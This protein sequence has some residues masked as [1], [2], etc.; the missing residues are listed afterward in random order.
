MENRL[1][2]I[3]EGTEPWKQ[4]CRDTW[5]SYRESYETLNT[6]QQTAHGAGSARQRLF[7]NGIKAVLGKKGPI[8][9]REGATKEDTVFF[10]WP[11]GTAFT[12]LTD[13]AAQ[14]FVASKTQAAPVFGTLDGKPIYKKSG[15]FGTYCVWNSTNVP[16]TPE[17]TPDTIVA[18]LKA[19]SDSVLHTLG[20]FVF[21]SGQYGPFMYKA[22]TTGKARKFVGIPQALD[23]KTLTLEAATRIFQEGL[24]Q[25]AKKQ[26]YKKNAGTKKE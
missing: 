21:R 24:K 5:N 2:K 26:A 14:A 6:Q 20:P 13:A 16:C 1:D 8:L 11:E 18:K 7:E 17:D 22:D 12:D 23:P 4:V 19:K 10:G 15:P 3:A 25:T 9:L